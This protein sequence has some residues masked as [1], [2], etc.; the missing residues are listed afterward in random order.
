MFRYCIYGY[1]LFLGDW[2]SGSN[3]RV[4]AEEDLA[5][6]VVTISM[7]ITMTIMMVKMIRTSMDVGTLHNMIIDVSSCWLQALH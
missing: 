3:L 2:W 1:L 6:Q 5:R 7:A 4:F